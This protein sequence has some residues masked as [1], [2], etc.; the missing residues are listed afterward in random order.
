MVNAVGARAT[1][2]RYS[3]SNIDSLQPLAREKDVDI[4]CASLAFKVLAASSD[5]ERIVR[6]LLDNAI[7]HS[8]TRSV[9]RIE[10]EATETVRLHVR[11]EGSGVPAHERESVFEPF[12][13]SSL[14]RSQADGARLGLSIARELARKHE[15]DVSI[16]E[17]AESCFVLTMRR[18]R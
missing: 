2:C 3:G 7:R 14:A 12:N 6:N 18:G 16:A 13:R 8:P 17:T 4:R 11:D 9:I 5:L 15:G 1:R 10:A